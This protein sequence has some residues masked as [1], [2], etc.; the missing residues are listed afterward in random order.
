MPILEIV[1]GSSGA[2]YL[3]TLAA[4]RSAYWFIDLMMTSIHGFDK[5]SLTSFILTKQH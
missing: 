3:K 4:C 1:R 2:A 5:L